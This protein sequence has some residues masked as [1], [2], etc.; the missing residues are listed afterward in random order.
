MR[1]Q[2]RRP[3]WPPWPFAVPPR[4]GDV[5]RVLVPFAIRKRGGRKLVLVP[6]G[7]DLV[8]DRP[9]VDNA[10][11][12]ALGHAFRR[13]KLLETGIYGT[14][15]ELAATEKANPSYVSR[16]L[17]MTLLAPDI[18]EAILDGRHPLRDVPSHIDA[19]VPAS[20]HPK[21]QASAQ[22]RRRKILGD[23][24]LAAVAVEEHQPSA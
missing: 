1:A 4:S 17:R 10:M 21:R 15:E 16:V 9:R 14:I 3:P 12:K 2:K 5:V 23:H 18:V 22:R 19:A 11:I 24:A 8:T 6:G 13:R 20:W 7:N